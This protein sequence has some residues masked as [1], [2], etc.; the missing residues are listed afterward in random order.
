MEQPDLDTLT[1]VEIVPDGLMYR[2]LFANDPQGNI[3]RA[4]DRGSG[5]ERWVLHRKHEDVLYPTLS[6]DQVIKMAEEKKSLKI[7]FS[8]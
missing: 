2:T 8:A 4:F 6:L 7:Y 1:L 3:W 5:A